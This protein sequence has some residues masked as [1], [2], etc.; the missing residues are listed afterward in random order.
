MNN[1]SGNLLYRTSDI[2]VRG[3]GLPLQ[4]GR[5]YNSTGSYGQQWRF[6]VGKD[7]NIEP[8]PDGGM[9]Y[10]TPSSTVF[11]FTPK[12]GGGFTTPAGANADLT[13][14]SPTQVKL[15]FQ[16]SGRTYLFDKTWQTYALGKYF[17]IEDADRHGN[18]ITYGYTPAGDLSTIT[19]TQGRVLNVTTTAGKITRIAETAP[20]TRVWNYAWTG[21]EL[22]TYTDADGK[23]TTY[24]YDSYP[25]LSSVTDPVGKQLKLVIPSTG[26]TASVTRVTNTTNGTGPT[27]TFAHNTT[28]GSPCTASGV[29]G[30]MT[31]T[32][33][34][35][36]VTNYCWDGQSR[37]IQTFDPLG[38]SRAAAYTTNSNVESLTD[39]LSAISTLTYDNLNN[40]TKMQAPGVGGRE[41]T[42]EYPTPV[43]SGPHALEFYQPT[44]SKDA[45][46]NETTYSYTAGRNLDTVATPGGA[47]GTLDNDYQG[48]PGVSC[49]GKPGELC[50]T[51]DGRGNATSYGYDSSGN[52]TSVTPPAPLGGTTVVPDSL[53]RTASMTD[54]KGQVTL[55]TY[56]KLD[57]IT[58][59]RYGGAPTCT[60]SAGN[61]ITY[62]YDA[63]GNLLTRTDNTGGTTFAYDA[64]HRPTSKVTPYFGSSDVTYDGVGNILTFS[65]D[66]STTTTY[67]YDLA[68]NLDKL[69]EPGG[70][71]TGY[72]L[73][74]LPPASAKCV[75]FDQ[76]FNGRRTL[77]RFPSGQKTEYA[78]DGS[79]RQTSVVGKRPAGT[80]FTSR[81]YTYAHPSTGADT[82]LRWSM[83]EV[84]PGLADVSSTYGYDG[85]DQL[86]AATRGA[87]TWG[88]SYD[89]AGNRTQLTQTG[90]PTT[91]YGYNNADMLCW[92]GPTAGGNGTTSCPAT[93]A[94]DTAHSYD[95]NGNLTAAG[96][97]TF[98]YNTKN[99]TSQVTTGGSPLPMGYAD[100][101][102]TERDTAGGTRFANDL[103][104]ATGQLTGASW[105]G[106]TREP[107]G[108]L[109]SLRVG[110][111]GSSVNS[112]YTHD[113]LG[114]VIA[115]TDSTGNTDTAVITYDPYGTVLS[116]TG[117]QAALNPWRYASGYHDTATGL[118]KFGTR[119][120]NPSLGRWTQ[121][122]PLAGSIDNPS[123]VNRYPYVGNSPVNSID[124]TG[125]GFLSGLSG[126]AEILIGG[127]EVA[128]A[129]AAGYASGY[130]IGLLI[131][132]VVSAPA[133]LPVILGAA[134]GAGTFSLAVYILSR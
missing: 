24:G 61:C 110:T 82:D 31:V 70:T 60:P 105:L 132:G 7:V 103:L 11:L 67:A 133:Y 131:L 25:M 35:A 54:G 127:V 96:S 68:N 4:V 55:L 40:L 119:Y 34:N 20:R 58:Q 81:S 89:L 91:F 83:A 18:K 117:S 3:V 106:F 64:L 130:Y 72:S 94:G 62:A 87:T 95:G 57:R 36:G 53:G 63:V 32:G 59:V 93:P 109:I 84:N 16:K 39:G 65:E 17:L 47:G 74:A 123:A 56:D 69:A 101:D 10:T 80:A 112:Y 14:V 27:Y 13:T 42:L 5:H 102:S 126:L 120:Y 30:R 26:R 71:C 122:D 77:A 124:P 48:D 46:G 43:G 111:G 33:P 134:A 29:M 1:A 50:K 6:D 92:S 9:N 19:D 15:T 12:T 37:V 41:S 98:G 75:L 49:G 45:Q 107:S 79:G 73:T 66:A 44:T 114:S 116:A 128:L 118:T 104:G 86:T 38:R 2:S 78:Y 76:D 28:G 21:N 113:G 99:Q 51:T 100:A 97:Q 108:N 85:M 23:I 121:R 125:R 115:L 88:Y 22:S 90:E 8:Q 52:L 129:G